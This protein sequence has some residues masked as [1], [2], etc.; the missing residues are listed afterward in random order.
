MESVVLFKYETIA[1]ILCM[2]MQTVGI[3]S[4]LRLHWPPAVEKSLQIMNLA[5]FQFAAANPECLVADTDGTGISLYNLVSLIKSS[6]VLG[7]HVLLLALRVLYTT[8][9]RVRAGTEEAAYH[10][11][12]S[13]TTFLIGSFLYVLTFVMSVKMSLGDLEEHWDDRTPAGT[14]LWTMG[15]LLLLVGVFIL[16]EQF[17]TV[18]ALRLLRGDATPGRAPLLDA[19]AA[20]VS[21]RDLKRLAQRLYDASQLEPWT[22]QLR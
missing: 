10:T 8:A 12:R 1:I 11:R 21:P 15:L 14:A 6:V 7:L 20:R 17:F 19:V 4:A 9:A 2:H 3:V 16:V 22:P 13:D 18:H 5:A